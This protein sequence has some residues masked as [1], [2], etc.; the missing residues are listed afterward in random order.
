[1]GCFDRVLPVNGSDFPGLAGNLQLLGFFKE[2]NWASSDN[3][4]ELWAFK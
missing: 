2:M 1:M 4:K 3:G